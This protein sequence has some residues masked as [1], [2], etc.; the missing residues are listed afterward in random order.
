MC[1]S[2]RH[3]WPTIIQRSTRARMKAPVRWIHDAQRDDV[4]RF[5]TTGSIAKTGVPACA[6]CRG[7]GTPPVRLQKRLLGSQPEELR[8][9]RQISNQN[10]VDGTDG[11]RNVHPRWRSQ[12][13]GGLDNVRCPW[14]SQQANTLA[15]QA[16]VSSETLCCKGSLW[17]R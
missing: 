6:G 1:S 17:A 8:A 12:S 2:A 10:A 13:C 11:L 4:A 9:G 14:R 7:A 5:G 15:F 3:L 16:A